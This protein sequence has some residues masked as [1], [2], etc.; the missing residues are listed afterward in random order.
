M[1]VVTGA[2][3]Q[4]AHALHVE[5]ANGRVHTLQIV[6]LEADGSDIRVT[7]TESDGLAVFQSES[8]P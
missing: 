4:S 5:L 7:M 8:T 1:L 6:N 2:V 3:A